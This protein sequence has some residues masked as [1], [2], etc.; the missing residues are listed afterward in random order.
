MSSILQ[1]LFGKQN[2]EPILKKIGEFEIEFKIFSNEEL[3]NKSE[4]LKKLVQGGETLDNILPQAFALIR[5][6]SNRTLKQRHFDAQLIGGIALY[7]GKIAEM[8]T[9]E[10]KT[11]AATAPAYLNALTGKGVHIITVN[12]YLARRDAVWMGQIYDAIGISVSCLV[13]D[14][15]YIYDPTYIPQKEREEAE[16]KERDAVGNFKIFQDF[17]RPI[18]R[19]EA[20]QTDIVYGTNHEFGFDYLRDNLAYRSSDQVQRGHY[21]AIIDEVDSILIDE[22]R[23]PL[24]IAAP[25]IESSE[26]YKVF[27][28]AVKILDPKDDY[29]VDE[30][31]RSVIITD[32]GI[33]K[34]E[35]ILNIKNIYDPQNFQLVH[36]LEESLKAISLFQKDKNYVVKNEEI[37]IVDEFTGRMMYGRRYSGGLHQAI[38]AKEGVV[39]QQESRTYAQIT[40]QNYFRLYEKISGMTGT[41]QTSAE[42]FH[43]VYNLEVVSIPTNRPMIRK[44]M[45]DLIYKTKK[46]KYEAVV[47]E[48]NERHKIGQPILIGTASIEQNEI[49]SYLLSDAGIPHQVLNAKNHER[50][51]EIIAQ[52]G[53]QKAV[54]VATNMAGRGVDIILGGNPP[55]QGEAQ[56]VK[57]LGGLHVIGT[58]RHEARRI[59]NQLRGRSGRQ[60]DTG[61]SQFFLSLEDDLMR[62]FGGE[63]VKKLMETFKLPDDQ[64][65][66][67]GL[68][69]KVVN[70]AQKKVEG[71]NFDSRKH[72]LDYDDI[73][74]KQR[75]SIYNKRKDILVKEIPERIKEIISIAYQRI[76]L[77]NPD[78]EFLEGILIG[79]EIIEKDELNS[80]EDIKEYLATKAY[81]LITDLNE[82]N[83]RMRLL[84]FIDKLWMAHLE[85]LED[86]RS[87]VNI[88]AYGQHDPLVEYRRESFILFQNLLSSFED[89]VF[90]DIWKFIKQSNSE[91]GRQ[92]IQLNSTI[93]SGDKKIGRNDPCPC[94]AKKEDGQPIKYKH[95][96][97]KNV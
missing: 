37:I 70:E 48:V 65:I 1:K 60:G 24:I 92:T 96:H 63:R 53:K 90:Y 88:R 68:V 35:N 71:F 28:K 89:W 61:S 27:S 62:I 59:D 94:G 29:I 72:L 12:D 18:S 36:Y 26:Y 21:F 32:S 76:A 91:V 19:R 14:L 39:I 40:L 73:L 77:Q 97:G 45:P 2:F 83:I 57:D 79:A 93:L 20:Y 86:L 16:D 44:D 51:G 52:A 95:C 4:E 84:A 22:A 43:K 41:A 3:K 31:I 34:I 25:D 13:H 11:L 54:T 30:K 74:N 85:N 38:E 17:L 33:T 9:G 50:E 56:K 8:A 81:N 5:E 47:K 15:A 6:A 64:P 49:I 58:E 69:S 66:E 67:S 75:T 55:A 10:G 82:N 23:T 78:F 46:V 7:N 87:T 80:V 42:E